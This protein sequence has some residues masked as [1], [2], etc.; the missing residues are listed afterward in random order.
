MDVY[1]SVYSACSLDFKALTQQMILFC[2]LT[3]QNQKPNC[4]SGCEFWANILSKKYFSFNFH[5]QLHNICVCRG[6][7]FNGLPTS[8]AQDVHVLSNINTR[9]Y[10]HIYKDW[11]QHN[12]L[13]NL[14]PL[15]LTVQELCNLPGLV[16]APPPHPPR[17]SWAKERYGVTKVRSFSKG[18]RI[19]CPI[20][21]TSFIEIWRNH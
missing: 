15:M 20:L 2:P 5:S 14:T 4:C 1:C 6:G 21:K 3:G 17:F 13:P 10:K 8:H 16:S 9:M 11:L 12:S 18:F 19:W 7:D